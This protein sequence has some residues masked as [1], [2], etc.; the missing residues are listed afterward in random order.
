M[1]NPLKFLLP[2]FCTIVALISCAGDHKMITLDTLFEE[3]TD[4]SRLSSAKGM[5]YR[6]VQY[7]SYDRRSVSPLDSTWFSNEDGFGGEP[8]PG[9]EKVLAAPDSSGT[10]TYLICDAK[11]P[12]VVQRLWTAGISGTV[13]VYLDSP[14]NLIFQGKQRIFSGNRLRYCWVTAASENTLS[15][16]TSMMHLISRYLFQKDSG[17]NGPVRSAT[18]TSIM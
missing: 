9:F 11:G 18:F 6:V 4:M 10:G 7:S 12:G 2:A 5:D 3:M 15:H 8:I 13:R 17:W 1:K 16:F 14:D